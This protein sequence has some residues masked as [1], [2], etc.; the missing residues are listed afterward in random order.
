MTIA[1]GRRNLIT[2]NITMQTIIVD[3]KIN[4][5]LYSINKRIYI[6]NAKI[7]FILTQN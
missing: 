5:F 4:N 6:E 7:I 3:I 1:S 2:I